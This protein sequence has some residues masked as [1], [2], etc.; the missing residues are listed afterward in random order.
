M[1]QVHMLRDTAGA[2]SERVARHQELRTQLE[3]QLSEF[4]E[5]LSTLMEHHTKVQ[6]RVAEPAV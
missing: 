1:L 5:Q 3:E 2:E 6:S 4:G